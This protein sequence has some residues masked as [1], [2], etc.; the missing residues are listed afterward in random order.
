MASQTAVVLMVWEWGTGAG[1]GP[2]RAA[3][4]A[5][6]NRRY[7]N[8]AAAMTITGNGTA[9]K[10]I[11]TNA[12]AAMSQSVRPLSARFATLNNASTT[13]AS[14]AALT[15]TNRASANGSLP[16]VA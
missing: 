14:T 15:P 5:L 8:S 13:I 10:S 16:N 3:A 4:S 11:A 2:A 7:P 1:L 6:P 9:K 12:A